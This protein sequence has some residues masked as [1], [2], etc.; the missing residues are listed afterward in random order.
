LRGDESNSLAFGEFLTGQGVEPYRGSLQLT[1]LIFVVHLIGD[2]HQPLHVGRGIDRGG[3]SI[4]VQWFGELRS[5][6]SLWDEG[7]I[8]KERLSF[9]EFA[10]FLEEEFA[11]H[12][13]VTYGNGPAT[14]A[15]E[16]FAARSQVYDIFDPKDPGANLPRLSYDYAAAQDA[17]LKQRLYRGG[18]R[19]AVLLNKVFDDVPGAAYRE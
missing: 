19:L 6:H 5:F 16:S 2:V 11:G 18:R 12:G 17:L 8:A 9:S 7:L 3:N 4:K 13:S 14:W 15:L 10:T 1:A